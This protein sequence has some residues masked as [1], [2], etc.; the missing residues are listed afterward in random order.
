M[1][2]IFRPGIFHSRICKSF[3]LPMSI[4]K[5]V[6]LK[7]NLVNRFCDIYLIGFD[8]L[9]YLPKMGVGVVDTLETGPDEWGLIENGGRGRKAPIAN[10]RPSSHTALI[11]TEIF[12]CETPH[13]SS[14]HIKWARNCGNSRKPRFKVRLVR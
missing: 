2:F 8:N 4:Y 14:A 12:F 13:T 11:F 7:K 9:L 10:F 1:P 6:F 5:N 3:I